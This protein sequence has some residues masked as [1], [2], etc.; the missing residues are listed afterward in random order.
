MKDNKNV[1]P[2]WILSFLRKICPEHLVE[3]IEGDLFQKLDRDIQ[4][5]GEHKAK[6]RLI[7]NAIRYFRPGIVLRNKFSMELNQIYMIQY[8]L[9]IAYRRLLKSKSFSLI[10]ILGLS[11]GMTAFFLIFQY[12]NFE[13]SYDQFHKNKNTIYRVELKRYTN[14]ELQQE[15]AKTFP[16]IRSLFKD[17]FSEIEGYTGFYKTPA[18]TGFLFRYNGKIYNE[19]GGIVNPDSAFFKVFPSLLMRGDARTVLKEKKNLV[20]SESMAR[21]VFGDTDP[22][23][24]T[25]E[26]IDDHEEGTDF[27]VT[28]IVKDFPENSH[29][30]A[31]V[32]RHIDD[33]WPEQIA[34]HWKDA[35]LFTYITLADGTDPDQIAARINGLLRKLEKENPLVKGSLVFLKPMTD[36]HLSSHLK[37]E[38]EANGSMTLLYCLIFIG[39]I[40]LG[41]AW[42]NYI[43]LETARFISRTKDMGIRRII[44]SKKSDLALQYLVEYLCLT[45][46]AL[47]M[48]GLLLYVILP[49]FKLFTGVSIT[50]AHWEN[51]DVWIIA[52][53]LFAG[54]SFMVGIYPAVFLVRLNPV[55]ALKGKI[56]GRNTGFTRRSLVVVQFTA[57]LVLVAFVLVVNQQLNF[58]RIT[59]K[60]FDVEQV[61]ALR[62]PTAYDNDDL[63]SKH[64]AYSVFENRLLQHAAIKQ[65]TSSSAI[66]G[67]EIGFSYVNLIK[68][69]IHDPY[70]PT[71]YK[72]LFVDQ[73]YIPVY[74][75]KLLAGRNFTGA[76]AGEHWIAP[77]LDKN[78]TT[79]ILN[80]RATRQLGFGSPQEAVD[81]VVDFQLFNEFDKY[82]IIGVVEDYHHEAVKKEV[83]PTIFA[84]NYSTFQQVY[85]S[86]RLNAGSDTQDA[87]A[88][89]EKTW[90]E[91]FPAK[92]F[93]YF[94][95]DDYYDQQFKYELYFGRI[96]TLFAGIAVFIACLGILAMTLFEANAR[97]KEISIRKILGATALNLVVVLSKDHVRIVLF[98]VVLS[99]PLIYFFSQEWLS[100]YPVRIKMS[101]V[102]FV[103]PLG[104]ITL[105]IGII[106]IYQTIKAIQTNPVN[107]LKDE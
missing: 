34:D 77:W 61:I 26:R 23:G 56:S 29:I 101:T 18:N 11:T 88:A 38:L 35:F 8:Y 97:L 87:L 9:V 98:S 27:I 73:N 80:E 71:I 32:I 95:V 105:I 68:R 96:F 81:Q 62:N 36:I 1:F 55:A 78:W 15:S 91:V 82:R 43:N 94:F 54:G 24:Q 104:V 5:Y 42:I 25:L 40:I 102:F 72:T 3:E 90:K 4:R 45:T 30:H 12:V 65:V 67:T 66:P 57:S 47:G 52:F 74:G 100:G 21:K 64:N 60:K 44:G 13:M 37:D 48:A 63:Q 19:P 99:W 75:L 70:D 85:Y 10:N 51:P 83:Y 6:R 28:G 89:I 53:I 17:N 20:I 46:C 49:N 106:T 14:G 31:S 59:N 76:E 16:G 92:P 79:I 93:E 41:M 50:T 84:S 33:H 2:A 103:G 39:V 86:V 22:I 58:M 107:H 69:T 7:R